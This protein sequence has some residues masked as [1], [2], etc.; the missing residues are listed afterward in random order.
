MQHYGADLDES[1]DFNDN[2]FMYLFDCH[3]L[4]TISLMLASNYVTDLGTY[5]TNANL[6]STSD[7]VGVTAVTANLPYADT[8]NRVLKAFQLA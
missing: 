6:N 2:Y 1:T 5:R 4:H 3:Y 8:I 7:D